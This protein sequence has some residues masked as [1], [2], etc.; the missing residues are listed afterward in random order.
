MVDSSG[1]LFSWQYFIYLANECPH[2]ESNKSLFSIFSSSAG[3][4]IAKFTVPLSPVN[5]LSVLSIVK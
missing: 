2:V 3:Q 5:S 4:L 1:M